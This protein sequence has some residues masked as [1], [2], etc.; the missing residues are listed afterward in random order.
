MIQSIRAELGISYKLFT[1]CQTYFA[2]V[3]ICIAIVPDKHLSSVIPGILSEEDSNTLPNKMQYKYA[4]FNIF[5]TSLS[6][7]YLH[8]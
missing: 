5:L 3:I 6:F 4:N 7:I 8:L 2:I 1:Q